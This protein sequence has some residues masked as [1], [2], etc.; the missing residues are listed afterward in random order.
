MTLGKAIGGGLPV[1]AML[2]RPDIAKLFVP[3]KHGSTLGGNAICMAVSRTLFDVI[4]REKLV[5]R[6]QKL[7][8]AA[9]NRLRQEPAIKSK[10]TEVRGHGFMLGIELTLAPEKFVDK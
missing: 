9:M 5:E 7:G 2:A 1:G 8:E 3:G 4:D 10:I 6:A